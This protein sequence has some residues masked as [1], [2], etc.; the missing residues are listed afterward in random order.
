MSPKLG[1]VYHILVY[2]QYGI[3]T[4]N[5]FKL[6]I[7]LKVVGGQLYEDLLFKH[8]RQHDVEV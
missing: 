4:I 3:W 2:S 7:V 1:A 5:P 8:I 6:H